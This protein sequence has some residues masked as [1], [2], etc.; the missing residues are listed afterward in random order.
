[1]KIYYYQ[2]ETLNL[3][4]YD[5]CTLLYDSAS[6]NDHSLQVEFDCCRS[7][8]NNLSSEEHQRDISIGDKLKVTGNDRVILVTKK[9]F[10]H[11]FFR[12]DGNR[13]V[14]SFASLENQTD[15]NMYKSMHDYTCLMLCD[16]LNIDK[17]IH[18]ET[19]GCV[20]AFVWGEDV[21]DCQNRNMF[22]CSN[23]KAN[24]HSRPRTDEEKGIFDDLKALLTPSPELPRVGESAFEATRERIKLIERKAR[25]KD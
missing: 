6:L 11:D 5:F 12:L 10:E 21:L 19:S 15:S 20:N 25:L 2:D 18:D 14:I 4:L 9:K 23:C 1:M 17:A 24:F 7:P 16:A 3:E 8:I 13:Y 22:F